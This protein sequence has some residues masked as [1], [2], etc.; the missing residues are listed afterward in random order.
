ML[1]PQINFDNFSVDANFYAW[2]FGDGE[3]DNTMNPIHTYK[4]DGLYIVTLIATN[5]NGCKDTISKEILIEPE[6]HFYIPNAFTP[7]QRWD[8]RCFYGK[9]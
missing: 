4:E 8:E 1:N 3:T 6:Y 9:R 2:T 7:K 5:T